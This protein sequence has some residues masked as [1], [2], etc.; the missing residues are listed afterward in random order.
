MAWEITPADLDRIAIGAGILG[1]GG[2]GN[3]ARGR[4]RAQLELEAGSH[5]HVRRLEELPDDA[6][7]VPMGG[8]GAP[9]VGL[10]KIGRGDEGELAVRAIEQHFGVKVAATVPVE[11]GGGNS[12]APLIAAGRLGLVTVDADGMG[13]AF[14]EG[15]M[16]SYYFDGKA[17]VASIMI[18]CQHRRIT[19]EGIPGT[20]E[21]ERIMRAMCVQL[22]G[23]AMVAE[24][25]ITVSRMKEVAIPNT[26][27]QARDL[28]DAVLRAQKGSGDPVDEICRVSG[29][30]RFFRG[31]LTDVDRRVERGYN[32]GRLTLQGTDEWRG[33]TAI[34]DVQN[35]YLII[36]VD[37]E[38]LA[39]VPDIIT[40]V[41]VERGLPVTTEV[42]RYGLR[43]QVLGIPAAPQL[44]TE[45]ALQW[46]G[47]RA[48]GY[49]LDFTP[50][51]AATP[52]SA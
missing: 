51:A 27:S 44:K 47:P 10:E 9:T 18:D 29:G 5:F 42:V 52:A 31:K 7:V 6:L 41:D 12:I 22:G 33:S 11:I 21:Q 48:F 3:P 20:V 16:I 45:Q 4:I 26:L 36:R 23:G 28:G 2:G 8:M 35:E 30:R 17:S 46:V 19:F 32:F 24:A 15:S 39:T 14:P 34:I 13:R 49:D 1:A 50:L 25:P 40:L 37:G 38:I 43:V